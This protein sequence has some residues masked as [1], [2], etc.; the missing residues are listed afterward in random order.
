MILVPREPI[1][2]GTRLGDRDWLIGSN[3]DRS[4]SD[5]VSQKQLGTK[6]QA[7]QISNQ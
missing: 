5:D 6:N 7:N 4:L 1:S 3:Q 2:Q